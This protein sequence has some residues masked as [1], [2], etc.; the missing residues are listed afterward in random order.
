MLVITILLY[1]RVPV[2]DDGLTAD[3]DRTGRKAGR[4]QRGGS[5]DPR[6]LSRKHADHFPKLAEI[7]QSSH[8]IRE[9]AP[10]GDL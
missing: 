8:G 6:A 10:A 3:P 4:R 1:R 2:M 9:R 5:S 7:S